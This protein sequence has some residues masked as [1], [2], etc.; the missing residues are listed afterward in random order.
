MG[1]RPDGPLET[2]VGEGGR[3]GR[4]QLIGRD[5]RLRRRHRG[6]LQEERRE[7]E[8]RDEGE[9]NRD[10]SLVSQQ[11]CP[12]VLHRSATRVVSEIVLSLEAMPAALTGRYETRTVI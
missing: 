6:E 12:P 8:K 11:A 2:G 10:A 7:H 4:A 5:A 9:G 3:L 1:K